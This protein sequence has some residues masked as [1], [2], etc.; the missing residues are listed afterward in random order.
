MPP[1]YSATIGRA[2][3]SSSL[4]SASSPIAHMPP[5]AISSV[6]RPSVRLAAPLARASP[7]TEPAFSGKLWNNHAKGTYDCVCCGTPLFAS[8]TK[9]DSGT[10][11]PSFYAPVARANVATTTDYKLGY[12]RTEVVCSTCGAHLGHVFEG[13]GYGTPTDQRYC[14]NSISMTLEP[15]D[16][17]A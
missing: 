14:I 4:V 12:A 6:P 9:F 10:G 8:K 1:T 13:E 2:N 17:T 16:V 5:A 11:W 3:S 7:Q 15:A